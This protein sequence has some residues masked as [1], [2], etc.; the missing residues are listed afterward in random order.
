MNAKRRNQWKKDEA[1][2]M[3]TGSCGVLRKKATQLAQDNDIESKP[4]V[5]LG[6]M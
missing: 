3:G 6:G 1:G 4:R 5:T 2:E